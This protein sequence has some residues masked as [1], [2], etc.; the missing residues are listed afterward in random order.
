MSEVVIKVIENYT[1]QSN[2][3]LGEGVYLGTEK[4]TGEKVAI[5]KIELSIFNKDKYL[6]NSIRSEIKLLQKFTHP[7]IIKFIDVLNSK[8]NL[9]IVTE[10]CK[11][12]DLK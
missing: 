6:E 3:S 8:S 7:N 1:Y 5:K 2:N 12:G 9:Y 11:D 10:Y 4:N